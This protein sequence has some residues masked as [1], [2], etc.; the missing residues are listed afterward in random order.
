MGKGERQQLEMQL[1]KCVERI[2]FELIRE[3]SDAD[4]T[5]L[6]QS[7]LTRRGL[8]DETE[9]GIKGCSVCGLDR[10]NS[11]HCHLEDETSRKRT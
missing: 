10:S 1:G 11:H 5:V 3:C 7:S 9:T 6:S 8:G 2:S 4:F